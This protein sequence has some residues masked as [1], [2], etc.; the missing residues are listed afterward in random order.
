MHAVIVCDPLGAELFAFDAVECSQEFLGSCVVPRRN[1]LLNDYE[2]FASTLASTSRILFTTDMIV[3]LATPVAFTQKTNDIIIA[4]LKSVG[5]A[6]THTCHVA[7]G[8]QIGFNDVLRTYVLSTTERDPEISDAHMTPP[9]AE[10]P[11]PT[12]KSQWIT[13]AA[14]SVTS[15]LGRAR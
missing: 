6:V 14:K 15:L 3:V 11:T 2:T 12:R 10:T 9:T 5:L 13:N 8:G 7:S 4:A 1:G